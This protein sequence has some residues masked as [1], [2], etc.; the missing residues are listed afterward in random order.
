MTVERQWQKRWLLDTF[1]SKVLH[2]VICNILAPVFLFRSNEPDIDLVDDDLVWCDLFALKDYAHLHQLRCRLFIT[3]V[4]DVGLHSI[5]PR[6][7]L[8]D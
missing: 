1:A 4:T 2:K 3:M 7:Q 8:N 6:K 5:T